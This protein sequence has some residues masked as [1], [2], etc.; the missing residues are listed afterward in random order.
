MGELAELPEN[1]AREHARAIARVI[2]RP[3]ALAEGEEGRLI[4]Q[5]PDNDS[6]EELLNE[7]FFRERRDL[8]SA[9]DFARSTAPRRRIPKS[10]SDGGGG[11][12]EGERTEKRR[13]FA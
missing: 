11:K 8:N 5:E 12:G 2:R 13:I 4:R 10:P 1:R 3:A 9:R 6:S 7:N